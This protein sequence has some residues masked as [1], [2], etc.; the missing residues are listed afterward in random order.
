[1]SENMTAQDLIDYF[2]ER[3]QEIDRTQWDIT[4]GEEPVFPMLIVFMGQASE[5]GFV[6]I[7]ENLFRLWP[8]YQKELRFLFMEKPISAQNYDEAIFSE[9]VINAKQMVETTLLDKSRL[10]SIV[11]YMFS[12]QNNF[13]NKREMKIYYILDTTDV[14]DVEEYFR[15]ADAIAISRGFLGLNSYEVSDMMF[16]LLDESIGKMK[17]ADTVKNS[18]AKCYDNDEEFPVKSM[19]LLSNK[20]S[21]NAICED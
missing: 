19:F 11:S 3:L 9:P 12:P 6:H 2:E 10:Q 7:A 1:M 4:V 8:Q 5:Q 16:L 15:W 17:I 14:N 13:K 21:D 20:R 18:L